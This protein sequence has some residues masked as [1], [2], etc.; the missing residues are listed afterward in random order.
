MNIIPLIIIT[1]LVQIASFSLRMWSIHMRRR[2]LDPGDVVII[3]AFVSAY[4]F[5]R[6]AA[7]C[8]DKVNSLRLRLII[9][10]V[11]PD[12]LDTSPQL[13]YVITI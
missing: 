1:A 13:W 6:C 3:I 12:E 4:L 5:E 7:Y 2:K 11:Y 9:R 10:L 8:E